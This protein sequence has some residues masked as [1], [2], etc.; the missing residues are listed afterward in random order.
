MATLKIYD[1]IVSKDEK[2]MMLAWGVDEGFSFIDT[3]NFIASIPTEDNNIDMVINSR[4]GDAV[5]AIAIYDALRQSGKIISADIIGQCSSAATII[6]LAAQKE[7]RSAT[8]NATIMIH[9]PYTCHVE[10]NAGELQQATNDLQKLTDKYLDIYE[11]RTGTDRATLQTIM[12]EGS[13]MNS[14]KAL[15]LGFINKVDVP[16]SARNDKNK[17][18]NK[19]EFNSV[20]KA[21]AKA[22]GYN[23]KA[24]ELE[25]ADGNK[26]VLEKESGE[27]AVGDKV[28]SPDGDYVMP[29]GSTIKVESGAISEIE[30]AKPD[31]A[32]TEPKPEPKP[33]E[34]KGPDPSQMK[35][36]LE[37]LKKRC[38]A[39]EAELTEAKGKAKSVE[40]ITILNA[41]A[42]AG[43][44]EWLMKAK[45]NY[46]VENVDTNINHEKAQNTKES[47][48]EYVERIKAEKQK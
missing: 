12:D 13:D 29:D 18:M 6:L 37:D 25:T 40:D 31:P 46:K 36:E 45:S 41:V 7:L 42:M 38:E 16:A 24:L 14:Q 43:G 5:E 8:A 2:Q 11:E 23:F 34:P 17:I 30:R 1:D 27:P 20:V 48:R 33:G 47:Y 39:L 32:K 21:V 3:D 28:T 19:I 15:E 9:N 44:R 10:G 4:G 35:Q 26:L 22:L